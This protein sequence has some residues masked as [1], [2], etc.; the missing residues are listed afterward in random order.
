MRHRKH[1]PGLTDCRGWRG[2]RG[3]G[4]ADVHV[5]PEQFQACQLQA[6]RLRTG[7]QTWEEFGGRGRERLLGLMVVREGERQKEGVVVDEGLWPTKRERKAALGRRCSET[8]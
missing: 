8:A 3:W 6:G 5:G 7:R 1:P 4:T 2:W